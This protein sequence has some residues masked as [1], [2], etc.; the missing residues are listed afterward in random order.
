MFKWPGWFLRAKEYVAPHVHWFGPPQDHGPRG[1]GQATLEGVPCEGGGHTMFM[2][3]SCRCG[4]Y[5]IFPQSNYNLATLEFKTVD[6]PA[7]VRNNGL[8][9]Q[10]K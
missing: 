10:V 3:M 7:W 4:D 1:G 8:K 9:E 2:V 5:Q 6:F